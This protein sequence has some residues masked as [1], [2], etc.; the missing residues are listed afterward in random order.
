VLDALKGFNEEEVEM[1]S[2]AEVEARNS[3][4]IS[5][6]SYTKAEEK[7]DQ[8]NATGGAI[9]LKLFRIERV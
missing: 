1:L 7:S 3:K 2:E 6:V 4:I 8:L 5:D 9:E